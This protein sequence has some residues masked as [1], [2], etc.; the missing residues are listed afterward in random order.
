M[1]A[2]AYVGPVDIGFLCR[3]NFQYFCPKFFPAK[4]N[5]SEFRKNV[6]Q[7]V[8]I[9]LFGGRES[10]GRERIFTPA[11]ESSIPAAEFPF[12]R[13][14]KKFQGIR[15]SYIRPRRLFIWAIKWSNI[16]RRHLPSSNPGSPSTTP[17]GETGDIPA[18]ADFDGDGKT[19]VAVWRPSNGYWHVIHSATS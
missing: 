9:S 15:K 11:D 10:P 1:L 6:P 7:N 14:N 19:D 3:F 4:I 18:P 13:S 17:F 5:S 16:H 8:K 12:A 2:I